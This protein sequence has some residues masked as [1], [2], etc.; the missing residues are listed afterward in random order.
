MIIKDRD[1]GRGQGRAV[2]L[3]RLLD[4]SLLVEAEEEH[5]DTSSLLL[6]KSLCLEGF[7][8]LIYVVAGAGAVCIILKLSSRHLFINIINKKN[9]LWPID[10]LYSMRSFVDVERSVG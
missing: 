3:Q 4:D 10:I 9:L 7:R 8:I 1:V 6:A 2:V 5:V